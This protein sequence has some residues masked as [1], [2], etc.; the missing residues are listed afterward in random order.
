MQNELF[1]TNTDPQTLLSR[2]KVRLATLLGAMEPGD[3]C[4]FDC[5]T[6]GSFHTAS[7]AVSR[8]NTASGRKEWRVYTNNN[9]RTYIVERALPGKTFPLITRI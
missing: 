9:G 5:D 3:R 2:A 1:F 4:R 7:C 6:H 8:L